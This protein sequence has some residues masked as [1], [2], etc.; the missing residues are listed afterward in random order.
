MQG[1]TGLDAGLEFVPAVVNQSSFNFSLMPP[2]FK[3]YVDANLYQRYISAWN[4]S[5]ISSKIAT[6]S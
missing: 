3:I 4:Y 1:E 2:K 6:Y 5:S